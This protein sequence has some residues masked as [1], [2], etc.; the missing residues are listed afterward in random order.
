MS[1]GHAGELTLSQML[2]TFN[3]DTTITITFENT[4]S[5]IERL[6]KETMAIMDEWANNHDGA[7]S[8]LGILLIVKQY[9]FPI[10]IWEAFEKV[11]V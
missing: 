8:A 10:D 11:G 5:I 7:S 3:N 6:P 9:G 1:V 2:E 4:L